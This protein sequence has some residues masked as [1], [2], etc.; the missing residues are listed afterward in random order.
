MGVRK[1]GELER[2]GTADLSGAVG[3]GNT[4]KVWLKYVCG[5]SDNAGRSGQKYTLP[6][7]QFCGSSASGE[8]LE[9]VQLKKGRRMI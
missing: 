2:A 6:N 4:R 7:F 5:A 8:L 1:R 9:T 3:G